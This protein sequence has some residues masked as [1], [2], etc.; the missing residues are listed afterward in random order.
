MIK[1]MEIQNVHRTAAVEAIKISLLPRA[2]N[3][4]AW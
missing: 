3:S 1:S 2:L 4:N